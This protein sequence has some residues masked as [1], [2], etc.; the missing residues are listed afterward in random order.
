[1]LK[2]LFLICRTVY[3]KMVE[4]KDMPFFMENLEMERKKGQKNF[5]LPEQ[6]F[7]P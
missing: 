6:G 5:D 4:N 2:S 7:E 3:S 1:M